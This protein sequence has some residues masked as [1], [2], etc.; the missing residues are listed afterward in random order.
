ML[1]V[2]KLKPGD[3]VL[4]MEPEGFFRDILVDW[5]PLRR[6][7]ALKSHP[8]DVP[9]HLVYSCTPK[10]LADTLKGERLIHDYLGEHQ[11]T[12]SPVWGAKA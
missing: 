4:I 10:R 5:K 1:E 9:E 2:S 7:V 12:L 3:P 6:G 11:G 8:F